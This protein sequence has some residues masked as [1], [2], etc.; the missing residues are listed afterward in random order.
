MSS[1]LKRKIVVKST[2]KQ[3]REILK[4]FK[5]RNLGS[6]IIII[7]RRILALLLLE[8]SK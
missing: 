4:N 1:H 2:E 8:G 7:P 5:K 3:E 6:Q